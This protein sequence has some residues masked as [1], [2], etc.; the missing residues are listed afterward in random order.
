MYCT[1]GG[2]GLREEAPGDAAEPHNHLK[3]KKALL[4]K[5]SYRMDGKEK[6]CFNC[7][8]CSASTGHFITPTGFICEKQDDVWYPGG[9]PDSRCCEK[10]RFPTGI[11]IRE[12]FG[13]ESIPALWLIAKSR[14]ISRV[15]FGRLL[16]RDSC[17]IEND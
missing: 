5:R 10:H 1:H 15:D 4:L 17:F 2:G 9:I 11:T 13:E 12:K 6:S 7:A 16:E 14:G 3:N 8:F